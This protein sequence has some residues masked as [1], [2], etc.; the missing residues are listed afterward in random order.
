MLSL[1][2]TM[3]SMVYSM[4]EALKHDVSFLL[5]SMKEIFIATDAQVYFM[6]KLG[7]SGDKASEND[8]E[9]TRSLE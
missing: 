9:T 4:T 2:M 8:S 3:M 5:R 1:Q 7:D 6:E